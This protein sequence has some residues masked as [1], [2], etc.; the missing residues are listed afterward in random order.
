MPNE[1]I[2]S[3]WAYEAPAMPS[4]SDYRST[5][6]DLEKEYRTVTAKKGNRNWDSRDIAIYNILFGQRGEWTVD[7]AEM[8]LLTRDDPNLAQQLTA[9]QDL[10]REVTGYAITKDGSLVYRVD[11][12]GYYGYNPATK[13]ATPLRD[14]FTY[15]AAYPLPGNYLTLRGGLQ[16]G[17]AVDKNG[18]PYSSN[19]D[20]EN[21]WIKTDAYAQRSDNQAKYGVFLTNAEMETVY[22]T[23]YEPKEPASVSTGYKI[24]DDYVSG[25]YSID[26][27]VNMGMITA[28][29]ANALKLDE[30][31]PDA[32][33]FEEI[34]QWIGEFQRE[35]LDSPDIKALQENYPE[36]WDEM[37][38]WQKAAYGFSKVM[39]PVEWGEQIGAT[40]ATL[41]FW[42]G[43]LSD[44]EK[45]DVKFSLGNMSALG[46]S[47]TPE[48]L[49][50]FA[51]DESRQ[52]II[53]EQMGQMA[54]QREYQKATMPRFTKGAAEWLVWL[55]TL[56]LGVGANAVRKAVANV[57]SKR[58]A[59]LST[60]K[61]VQIATQQ[62]KKLTPDMLKTM[63][64]AKLAMEKS[65]VELNKAKAK[66]AT[67]EIKKLTKE[68]VKHQVKLDALQT[69]KVA[70]GKLKN[71]KLVQETEKQIKEVA[72]ELQKATTNL[73][74][75]TVADASKGIESGLSKTGTIPNLPS[76]E[77]EVALL[78]APD[79]AMKL[80]VAARQ[81]PVIKHLIDFAS[82]APKSAENRIA[83]GGIA[84]AVQNIKSAQLPRV[85]MSDIYKA[86][87]ILEIV[88]G[89]V[90]NVTGKRG[91]DP[92]TVLKW[93]KEYK[94][95]D[96]ALAAK[97]SSIADHPEIKLL[98]QLLDDSYKM[99]E[100]AGVEMGWLELPAGAEYW[101]RE[102]LSK[103]GRTFRPPARFL[104]NV[105][106]R[107][108]YFQE[109]EEGMAKGIDYNSNYR[110]LVQK[111]LQSRYEAV[112]EKQFLD[113]IK[114]MGT[115]VF[116]TTL[117]MELKS[118]TSAA[119]Y[120][121][122]VLAKL[123]KTGN[124]PSATMNAISRRSPKLAEAINA[125]KS[126]K[127]LQSIALK[128]AQKARSYFYKVKGD[129]DELE[130]SKGIPGIPALEGWQFPKETANE[131]IKILRPT[132]V[133][134]LT[135]TV[136]Q[137]NAI[138]RFTV[139]GFDFGAPM[140]QGI[141]LAER[142]P[143]A[144]ARA[145]RDSF[146]AMVN[147][148]WIEGY[149]ARPEN[150]EALIESILRG[151]MSYGSSEFMEA[152]NFL[153]KVPILGRITKPFQ[154][155]FNTFL[156]VGRL[157]H[158]KYLYKPNMSDDTVK[159]LGSHIDNMMGSLD[160]AKLGNTNYQRQVEAA[161]LWFAPRYTR[162]GIALMM[163]MFRGGLRGSEARKAI[164]SFLT[165]GAGMY[166]GIA[167]GLEKAGLVEE[168]TVPERLDPRDYRF[169][170]I[171]IGGIHVG[172]GSFW[173]SMTKLLANIYK[174]ATQNPD[175]IVSLDLRDNPL[176]KW[177]RSRLSPFMGMTTD[178][179]IGETYIGESPYGWNN[180]LKNEVVQRS[181]PFW[182][183]PYLT[184]Y[185]R[186]P[187]IRGASEIFGMR[188]WPVKEWERT[189]ELQDKYT[190]QDTNGRFATYSELRKADP[191]MARSLEDKH[192][193]L[194]E[195][196][197]GEA[198]EELRRSKGFF[199]QGWALAESFREW[200]GKYDEVA[201]SYSRD[202]WDAE[203][204]YKKDGDETKWKDAIREAGRQYGE[205][206]DLLEDEYPDVYAELALPKEIPEGATKE[207]M[208]WVTYQNDVLSNTN[209]DKPEGYDFELRS[210]LEGE[211]VEK[212]GE[213]M[214]KY[215]KEGLR[216]GRN[217]P[218]LYKARA[219]DIDDIAM[220]GY[221]DT[222]SSQ[223]LQFRLDNPPI[224]AKLYSWGYIN[225]IQT[226]DAA[227]IAQNI[228]D[229]M[230]LPKKVPIPID[231]IKYQADQ[232]KLT[233]LREIMHQRAKGR[234]RSR[235]VSRF[236]ESRGDYTDKLRALEDLLGKL[237][238]PTAQDKT[239]DEIA[240][241]IG[242]Y[243]Q[244]YSTV[245]QYTQTH[246]EP[247][248]NY[249]LAQM[250]KD[251]NE[252]AYRESRMTIK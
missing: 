235:A 148:E 218:P 67:K 225:T 195:A 75:A 135:S 8:S 239:L 66:A 172:P 128:E 109:I 201:E 59:F 130:K 150:K 114:P 121:E 165:L 48:Q 101:P 193:D 244:L 143:K 245:Q 179:I 203:E 104:K 28:S 90:K 117:Q 122:S 183:E 107:H 54:W 83:Q 161:Y 204:Q 6:I 88:D 11:R 5:I 199:T 226:Q 134:P 13:Q 53:Q 181:V 125:G 95:T 39:K 222:D 196:M 116:P 131:I 26:D 43:Q 142:N 97:Y 98:R 58:A 34:D 167:E 149:M 229:I 154:R 36:V 162:S 91:L 168:R 236:M 155:S 126:G 99:A 173:V 138:V 219:S 18:V 191:G 231:R 9:W 22:G 14:G 166:L 153:N 40:L 120:M 197:R 82:K 216:S 176:L 85:L 213:D 207:Y 21:Q 202:L 177:A 96:P 12:V 110:L 137:I 186:P 151:N 232:D 214:I 33:T 123:P 212:W 171:N 19:K 119:K 156:D 209:L 146:K 30:V 81:I 140:I 118:A 71:S 160:V 106:Q 103:L 217:L 206:Q 15:N 35:V 228:I 63:E 246:D 115:D 45:T 113:W 102:A 56:G 248:L 20:L 32:P 241:T 93:M 108:R 27:L 133:D 252:H 189:K 105:D 147:P 184:E 227:D 42:W 80:A 10:G 111:T 198:E 158:F 4:E 210:K 233:D 249:L 243:R 47:L 61:A 174:T 139:T 68:V 223:R 170:T 220:S 230:E 60:E 55:P 112:A 31:V 41:P 73:D 17:M 29:D 38:W 190:K 89:Q 215:V 57:I 178:M 205:N 25:S 84:L 188:S 192:P 200:G 144:W 2:T 51:D 145:F 157:E 208:A 251:I 69:A 7:S 92:G 132:K 79:N 124:V 127:E 250:E 163:D 234:P 238:V 44:G 78:F 136:S 224:E 1:D 72:V 175:R 182:I 37:K 24:L 74:G 50:E 169:G 65:V 86:K 77:S 180:F 187:A 62:G 164:G 3:E 159:Q 129:I 70:A 242:K 23:D 64:K 100:K 76:V 87:P 94:F 52:K 237:T 152:A 46:I 49:T 16:M 141:L 194:R 247:W 221:W 185:P 211:F 240:E